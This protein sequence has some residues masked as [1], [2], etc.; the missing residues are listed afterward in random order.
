MGQSTSQQVL[1]CS[2]GSASLGEECRTYFVLAHRRHEKEDL[3]GRLFPPDP[4]T[5]D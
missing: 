5:G 3:E 2:P 1:H 4:L